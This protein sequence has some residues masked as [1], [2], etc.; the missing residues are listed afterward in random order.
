MIKIAGIVI[1]SLVLTVFLKGASKEIA[2]F[3]TI[4][5]TV[6][7]LAVVSGEMKEISQTLLDL[8]SNIDNGKSYIELLIKILGISLLSQFVSDLCSDCGENA[9]A[10]QSETVSKVIILIMIIP[11]FES[12]INIVSGL[13]K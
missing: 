11:L 2:I 8:S 4:A 5:A 12:V 13:L 10:S 6:V 1:I 9:L 7:L 3:I